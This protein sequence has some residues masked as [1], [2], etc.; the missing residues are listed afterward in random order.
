MHFKLFF[1]CKLASYKPVEKG[2]KNRGNKM[3][4]LFSIFFLS[5]RVCV[6]V[7]VI[8]TECQNKKKQ[9]I[10]CNVYVFA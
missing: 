4:L 9:R 3:F 7:C 6:C 2:A 10:E 8:S 5:F 1:K